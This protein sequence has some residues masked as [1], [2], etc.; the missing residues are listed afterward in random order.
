MSDHFSGV[1]GAYARFRP[2][3]PAAL[4]S[5][6]AALAPSCSF[7]WDCATGNGQAAV[8]LADHFAEVVATDHSAAQIAQARVHPRVEYRVAPAEASGLPS[9]SADLVTVAQ[10]LH[11]L[12]LD[13]FYA[14]ARRVAAPGAVVAA[15]C[16]N[17]LE[18]DPRVNAV[19]GRFYGQVVGP[20][21][22]PER[23]LLEAGYRT[24]AF[25]F[26]A[27]EPPAFA[28]ASAWTLAD[29]LGYL[30]TWSATQRYAAARRA[31]PVDL[32]RA[33]LAAAWGD[34]DARRTVRW[35]LHLRV[36]RVRA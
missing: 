29:L 3:Y 8:G 35:P 33:D 5:W 20:F 15:W 28:M 1:A 4:F 18:V 12:D 21:W 10:A 11:W 26:A 6:L 25:P 31:D 27:V 36:G 19:I 16:Y 17:L 32:V 9:G 24:L 7:A 30:S 13:R 14:E 22:P 34:A 23:R 2:T